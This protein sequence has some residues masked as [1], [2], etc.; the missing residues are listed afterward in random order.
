[1]EVE[2]TRGGGGR[3]KGSEEEL[4]GDEGEKEGRETTEK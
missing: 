1:M 4:G 2:W 3:G